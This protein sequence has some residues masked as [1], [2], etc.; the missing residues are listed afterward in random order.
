MRFTYASHMRQRNLVLCPCLYIELF[1][2]VIKIVFHYEKTRE[3]GCENRFLSR[4]R[5]VA[6]RKCKP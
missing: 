4:V 3:N 5:S 2:L 6:M 1:E